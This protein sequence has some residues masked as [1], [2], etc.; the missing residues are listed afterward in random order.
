LPD[1]TDRVIR[2]KTKGIAIRWTK[3]YMPKPKSS[4]CVE[5]HSLIEPKWISKTEGISGH[6]SIE[7]DPSPKPNRIFTHKPLEAGM[8]VSGAVVIEPAAIVLSARVRERIPACCACRA[9][10]AEWLV[11][12]L[13]HQTPCAVP[14][15]NGRAQGVGQERSRAHSIRSREEFIDAEAGEQ[16]RGDR[17][18]RLFLDRIEAIVDRIRGGASNG[19]A[20][21]SAKRII[22]EA[23]GEAGI[24]DARQ[25]IPRVPA[26]GRR[27]TRFR[28]RGEIA[29][30]IIRSDVGSE[31]DL[32]TMCVVGCGVA[33][34]ISHGGR[35]CE[36]KQ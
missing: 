22:R 10:H 33:Q 19:F 2:I 17:A 4:I 15:C 20:G 31:Q 7:V 18:P 8:I 23:C 35:R 6:I 34:G 13:R 12:V 32:L 16:I 11:G 9:R 25:L 1:A 27:D 28:H 3:P 36:V 26:I 21:S 14:Q 5:A 30:E 24:A 29:V